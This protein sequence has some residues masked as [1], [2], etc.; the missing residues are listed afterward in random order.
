MKIL[1]IFQPFVIV[2]AF[3]IH[4]IFFVTLTS[5]K[6][7]FGISNLM[8]DEKTK[9]IKNESYLISP[10]TGVYSRSDEF[11]NTYNASKKS[12]IPFVD[13][14]GQLFIGKTKSKEKLQ[15]I[16]SMKSTSDFMHRNYKKN[17]LYHGTSITQR[18]A[19]AIVPIH[20][21]RTKS[22]RLLKKFHHDFRHMHKKSMNIDRSYVMKR[23]DQ[24][25]KNKTQQTDSLSDGHGRKIGFSK[26]RFKR[27]TV[28]GNFKPYMTRNGDQFDL[29]KE[30][31]SFEYKIKDGNASSKNSTVTNTTDTSTSYVVGVTTENAYNLLMVSHFQSFDS[32]L[33]SSGNDT[34][35]AAAADADVPKKNT[36]I[37]SHSI[38]PAVPVSGNFVKR[39]AVNFSSS[40]NAPYASPEKIIMKWPIKRVVSVEGDVI[41]G[42]LMMVHSRGEGDKLCGPIMAQGGVQALEV[43]LYTLKMINK[44][45]HM[46]FKIGA[47]ILDDCDTDT[48]GLEMALDFIKANLHYLDNSVNDSQCSQVT[49]PIWGV[50]G[51]PSSI[52]SIQVSNLLRLFKIPMISPFSTSPELSNKHKYDYFCRTIPSDY[53]QVQVIAK[54]IDQLK[55]TYVSVIYEES[56]YGIKG[57]EELEK[58]LNERKICIAIKEKVLKDSGV[59][60]EAFYDKVVAKLLTKPLARGVIVFA[61]DQEVAGIMRAVKRLNITNRFSWIGSDGWS[62]R[63]LVSDGNEEVV[64]GTISVQPQ[65]KPVKGF[66]DYFFKRSYEEHTNPYFA[67]YWESRFECRLPFVP[68][69]PFNVNFK[70]SCHS[71][72]YLEVNSVEIEN[73]LQFVHQATCG[74]CHAL[75][76]MHADLCGKNVKGVCDKMWKS[77][78]SLFLEYIKKVNFTDFSGDEFQ[79]DENCDGPARYNI[80]HYKQTSPRVFKWIKVGNYENGE[81]IL[82]LEELQF[83]INETE[84]P[85]SSCSEVCKKGEVKKYINGD[86]C[87]W[88]CNACSKYEVVLPSDETECKRCKL[89]T[90]PDKDQKSCIDLEAV[91]VR[92]EFYKLSIISSTA[93]GFFNVVTTITV[94]MCNFNTA[95]VRASSREAQVLVLVGALFLHANAYSFLLDPDEV[96]CSM[97]SYFSGIG[98]VLIYG[99]LFWK[100]Y[101]I[102]RI[103]DLSS[104]YKNMNSSAFILLVLGL[105]CIQ[106]IKSVIWTYFIDPRKVTFHFRDKD[107]KIK[108][109]SAFTTLEIGY[110][111]A[112]LFPLTSI[113]LCYS[114]TKKITNTPKIFNDSPQIFFS[115][116]FTIISWIAMLIMHFMTSDILLRENVVALVTNFNGIVIVFALFYRSMF[117][118]LFRPQLNTREYLRASRANHT[119]KSS[120]NDDSQ[121]RETISQLMINEFSGECSYNHVVER[122]DS[123]VHIFTP[124]DNPHNRREI[125]VQVSEPFLNS[126]ISKSVSFRP[127]KRTLSLS[128]INDIAVFQEENP[129][130]CIAHCDISITQHASESKLPRIEVGLHDNNSN[131]RESQ[132]SSYESINNKETHNSNS[133][134][135]KSNQK[136]EV[137]SLEEIDEKNNKKCNSNEKFSSD[138]SVH[139]MFVQEKPTE[140]DAQD[141]GI[142]DDEEINDLSTPENNGRTHT[143]KHDSHPDSDI[144]Y[145]KVVAC[146]ESISTTKL[147]YMNPIK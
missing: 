39:D 17:R 70:K 110:F 120:Q 138:E 147:Q 144:V 78:G 140:E 100:S 73:Q 1:K 119:M 72:L 127:K 93:F 109:C 66:S 32:T 101:R 43:M 28:Q 46:P 18:K 91:H 115:I 35:A 77:R 142:L 19:S 145:F 121:Q 114:R 20:R 61:S 48:Y 111:I 94:Y 130:S 124:V 69:T 107:T 88:K 44:D 71:N 132:S 128:H 15:R 103:F 45:P 63:D 41:I 99:T 108:L 56:N 14:F 92:N 84:M 89:G 118:I 25:L 40:F 34:T 7:P 83:K 64:E 126:K 33:Y 50:V 60:N 136:A 24:F 139:E 112:Y 57:L 10:F 27:T 22:N 98:Y 105:C 68:V 86:K 134:T 13:F 38:S 2:I 54:I 97:Q 143:K 23:N 106:K 6:M 16:K 9:D 3:T 29:S 37:I 47:H 96:V 104:H 123:S 11:P 137:D 146:A 113:I 8:Y 55:W 81:L 131:S 102:V 21:K 58:V 135:T 117:I 87:C 30:H 51:A 49:K 5:S 116:R 141:Y 12:R 85:A 80:V 95:I 65:A 76:S 4:H 31:R 42:G 36:N 74:F 90:K 122:D 62:A 53:Y 79:F 82:N 52:T 67:E 133:S 125:S 26:N 129:S 75:I 59:P